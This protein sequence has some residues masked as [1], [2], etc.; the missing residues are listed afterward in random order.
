MVH[1]ALSHFR[2]I[3]H[4]ELIH[5]LRKTIRL[6]CSRLQPDALKKEMSERMDY[7][8]SLKTNVKSFIKV[9]IRETMNCQANTASKPTEPSSSHMRGKDANH[10][11]TK[12]NPAKQ[13]P[14]CPYP[15]HKEK[16][17]PQFSERLS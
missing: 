8:E 14:I 7:D 6:L 5:E 13:K 4:A 15:P 10:E 9:L 1:K 3:L 17:F 2:A 16:G 11:V 12:T